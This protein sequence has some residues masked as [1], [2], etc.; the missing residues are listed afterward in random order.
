MNDYR[1]FKRCFTDIYLSESELGKEN[2][3][4]SRASFLD[5]DIKVEDRVFVYNQYDKREM[6]FHFLLY[7]FHLC[8]VICQVK[9][10]TLPPQLK[11]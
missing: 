5:F 10:F 2:L 4:S 11:Y 8:A 1:E 3:D 6:H 7:V 9:Y